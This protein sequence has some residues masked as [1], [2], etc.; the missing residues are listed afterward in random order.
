[1]EYF[2]KSLLYAKSEDQLLCELSKSKVSKRNDNLSYY[3][4]AIFLLFTVI[5]DFFF[6]FYSPS[7]WYTGVLRLLSDLHLWILIG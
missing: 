2:G 4:I 1:M 5:L 7:D 3:F 6:L